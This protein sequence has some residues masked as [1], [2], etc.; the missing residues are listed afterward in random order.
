M[1]SLS[2]ITGMNITVYTPQAAT[3]L[4]KI[5]ALGQ[6][7]RGKALLCLLPLI[8]QTTAQLHSSHTLV[9]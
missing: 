5:I 8:A 1:G 9:K 7:P 2:Q 4:W 6:K 3:V